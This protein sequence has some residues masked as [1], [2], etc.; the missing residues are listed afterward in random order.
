MQFE[1]VVSTLF[2]RAAGVQCMPG[3]VATLGYVFVIPGM[4]LINFGQN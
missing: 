3:T 1:P 2:L 4:F